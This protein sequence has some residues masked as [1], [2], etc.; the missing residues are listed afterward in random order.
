MIATGLGYRE[1]ADIVFG[2]AFLVG[3]GIII[4]V[5]VGMFI[6]WCVFG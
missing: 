5:P 2:I 4:G 6:G 3:V 1:G